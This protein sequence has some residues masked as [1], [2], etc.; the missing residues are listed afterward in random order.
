MAGAEEIKQAV[1]KAYGSLATNRTIPLENACCEPATK[2]KLLRYG[3][4]QDE[5]TSLPESVIAM[6]DGCGNPTGL[7]MIG[8]G[9]T[10]LDLGSG[11]GIDVF[12]ASR[13][14]GQQGK[15]IGVDMTT[16]MVQKA[17]AN[18]Q[19]AKLANVEFRLGEIESLPIDDSS[20]DVIISNCVI[21]L[22]PDKGKVFREMYRVLKHGGRLAIADEVALRAFSKEERED[23]ARW[24]S[25]VTGAI[26][27]REYASALKGAGFNDVYVKQLRSS[28]ELNPPVFSAFVS[29]TKP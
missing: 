18:A 19:R 17:N 2:E 21:C 26:T 4:T 6:S 3:Y 13:K 5:L 10:V 7:G 24:C 22:S 15:V 25:C 23:S 27:E 9:E 1:K 11:G 14:V 12:L 29:A 8:E 16:E 20:V 28:G